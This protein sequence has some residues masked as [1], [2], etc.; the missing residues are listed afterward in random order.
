M[1]KLPDYV[2]RS[3]IVCYIFGVLYFIAYLGL[4]A[5]DMSLQHYSGDQ[6]H[7]VLALKLRTVLDGLHYSFFIVSSGIFLHLQIAIWELVLKRTTD[8]EAAE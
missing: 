1:K 4:G 3:P 5:F 8:L 2:R 7:Q 6:T